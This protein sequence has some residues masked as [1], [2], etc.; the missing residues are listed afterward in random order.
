[1]YVYSGKFDTKNIKNCKKQRAI[2]LY[3]CILLCKKVMFP[4]RALCTWASLSIKKYMCLRLN[5]H[6]TISLSKNEILTNHKI[7][8]SMAITAWTYFWA[9]MVQHMEN[10]KIKKVVEYGSKIIST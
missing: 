5:M 7:D 9:N 3:T 8:E 10:S 6:A 2:V 1:M 4:Q